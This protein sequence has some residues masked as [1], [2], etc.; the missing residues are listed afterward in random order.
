MGHRTRLLTAAAAAVLVA[1]SPGVAA[2]DHGDRPAER[3]KALGHSPHPA[4]FLGEPDGVRHINSDLAFWGD[5]A[6]NG[7]YDGFRV[8]DISSPREPREIVHQ[9]CNGDQG[10][11]FVWGD[12]LVRSWNSKKPEARLCDGQV[13]PAGFEGVHVFDVSDPADPV[14]I[15]AVE[16]PCGSHTLTGARD[17]DRLIVYSNNSSSTGCTGG[18]PAGDFI[19]VLQVPLDDPAGASL[20]RREPLEGPLTAIPTGCHDAGLILGEANLLACASAD[21]INVFDVGNRGGSLADPAFLFTVTEPGVGQAGTNG[22][23]HS[24]AFTWDG[25]VL[26]A[27][28]EPGGGAEPECETVD[29]P[30]DKSVFF[31]DARTGAKLGQWTLP[32]GQ[33]GVAEN[34]TVHNYNVVP[35]KDRYVL[36]SG[37]YQ[38]GTWVTEFTDPANP[39]TLGYAD[40]PALVPPDLGGAWSSY[41]YNDFIYESSITEGLNVFRYRGHELKGARQLDHLNPQTQE[42]TLH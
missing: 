4:T 8:I 37:N 17:G 7:N 11:V 5:L 21:A 19:D 30:V 12:V 16:L 31:Y 25:E 41:W 33:D 38:A 15:G 34:C 29:P 18:D 26:V 32:R 28:W 36:V 2:A 6:F 9:R 40:P 14:L 1:A 39:V 24:A 35:V 22:R 42:F 3:L 20:L 27:G 23:W 10:D 13:V